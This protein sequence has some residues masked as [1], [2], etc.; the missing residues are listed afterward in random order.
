[1]RILLVEDDV[2][3]VDFV[4]K[5]LTA[6]GYDVDDVADGHEA[7]RMLERTP[8]DGVVLDIMLTGRDG[9][10]VL[11]QMRSKGNATP[12]LIL[13]A[14]NEVAE[15]VEGLDA[16]AEDYVAKP[17]ALVELVA[18]VRALVRRS[19][20]TRPG[21]LRVA[22]LTL[23]P[24]SRTA[25][26]G[27]RRIE[28]TNREYRLLEFLMRSA[29]TVCSRMLILEAVWEYDFDPGTN[30]VD[31]FIAKLRDKIDAGSAVKLLHSVRREGYVIKAST[32]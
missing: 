2:K 11:R 9:L 19:G 25:E 4:S 7:L 28:L 6:E 3:T 22:D 24:A 21:L 20:S 26:R 16:G 23:D 30:I 14:R 32:P 8:Y 1:M 15:K 29:G 27:G 12:V 17:F 10:G 31:V 5:A 18:R 13:S